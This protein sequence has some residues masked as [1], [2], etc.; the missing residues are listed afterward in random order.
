MSSR[1]TT[2]PSMTDALGTPFRRPVVRRAAGI[3]LAGVLATALVGCAGASTTGSSTTEASSAP[4]AVAGGAGVR[5][6]GVRG[7]IAELDGRTLQ[8]QGSD[9][10]TAVT[11]TDTTAIT[12]TVSG[13]PADITPGVCVTVRSASDGQTPGATAAPADDPV[14]SDQPVE[15]AS[16]SV[17]DAVDGSCAGDAFGGGAGGG[18]GGASDGALPAG[19]ASAGPPGGM[20]SGAPDGSVPSGAPGDR[21]PSGVPTTGA[22][23]GGFGG[24]ASGL[25]TAV[26]GSTV[27][28]SSTR[29]E[30]TTTLTV[31]LTDST[32]VTRRVA[33]T[34]SDLAVGG[35]VSAQGEVDDTGA[36]TATSLA[37]SAATDGQCTSGGRQ[38]RP[39]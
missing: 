36:M 1:S 9:G 31:V 30:E 2:D 28:I 24:G 21:M 15:A 14:A 19:G 26:D 35:C 37:L 20:P 22:L 17:T 8:V 34:A 13:T 11:Y 7:L 23:P 33:G 32:T 10:Q 27:T 5:E 16:V 4:S 39:S 29:G 12:A 6:P 38:G 18:A 3:A 25:V